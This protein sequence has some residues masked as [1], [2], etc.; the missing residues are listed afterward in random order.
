MSFKTYYLLSISI[1]IIIIEL[2]PARRNT[3][4]V[5]TISISSVPLAKIAN[6]V[7]D[8][9]FGELKLFFPVDFVSIFACKRVS[10]K[11][12]AD[13]LKSK[14]V[15]IATESATKYC[16]EPMIKLTN[17]V[18]SLTS[19]ILAVVKQNNIVSIKLQIHHDWCGEFQ[20]NRF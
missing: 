4:A 7:F 16:V 19:L 1:I 6:A 9:I 14:I 15:Y 17:E 5:I 11:V 18:L 8:A 2:T 12:S 13:V 10:K 3:L 20:R